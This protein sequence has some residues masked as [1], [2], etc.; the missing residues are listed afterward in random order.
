[1]N[2]SNNGYALSSLL[3][4]TSGNDFELYN[5]SAE[6]GIFPNI[7]NACPVHAPSYE[8]EYD[9]YNQYSTQPLVYSWMPIVPGFL[10]ERSENIQKFDSLV[11]KLQ[12]Q[13]LNISNI[14]TEGNSSIVSDQNAKFGNS[15]ILNNSDSKHYILNNS[16]GM[17]FNHQ[18]EDSC[19]AMDLNISCNI[20]KDSTNLDLSFNGKIPELTTTGTDD[21]NQL[22]TVSHEKLV[23]IEKLTSTSCD[24]T[25]NLADRNEDECA[26]NADEE[27]E[28]SDSEKLRNESFELLK[29][30]DTTKMLL[31]SKSEKSPDVVNDTVS[32][33]NDE[34]MDDDEQHET[35]LIQEQSDVTTAN[36]KDESTIDITTR[37]IPT[38]KDHDD[39][40]FNK[41]QTSLSE[42]CPPPSIATLP[43]SLS[44]IIAIYKKN[45]EKPQETFASVKSNSMFIPSHPLNEAISMEWPQVAEVKAHGIMYNRSTDCEH[46]EFMT[47]KYVERFIKAETSSSYNHKV[48]PASAKK[49]VER[50]K[51]VLTEHLCCM[52]I[53][54]ILFIHQLGY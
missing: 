40:L 5:T 11:K 41:F 22:E 7:V 16:S 17:T 50:L 28:E 26:N 6:E 20:Q 19:N 45:S 44:E 48:G 52:L 23:D 46:I 53:L 29:Q 33:S 9:Y 1:M 12:P 21:S 49:K 13:P 14:S 15:L 10:Q 8:P 27:D 34:G 24:A 31:I 2:L 37:R 47:V 36:I 38:L 3:L 39:F 51:Y 18:L 25:A 30:E 4:S 54:I 32:D 42:L 43:L 35:D